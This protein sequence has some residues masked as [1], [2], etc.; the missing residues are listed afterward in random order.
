[1]SKGHPPSFR[2]SAASICNV[3]PY[4]AGSLSQAGATHNPAQHYAALPEFSVS[5]DRDTAIAARIS[6]PLASDST[7]MRP[8]NSRKRSLRPARPIPAPAPLR[9]KCPSSSGSIPFPKS[10]TSSF[11]PPAS[12]AKQTSTE[13]LWA[14]RWTLL[15]VGWSMRNSGSSTERGNR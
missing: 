9:L 13:G 4:R 12:M 1:V 6:V 10:F 15:R 7:S 3:L 14:C 11:A 8:P 5:V 2:C